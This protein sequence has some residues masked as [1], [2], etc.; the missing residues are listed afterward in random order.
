MNIKHWET[1]ALNPNYLKT[2][3]SFCPYF[4]YQKSTELFHWE[5]LT[6]TIKIPISSFHF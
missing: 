2:N 3:L 1:L 6:S 4:T 5:I